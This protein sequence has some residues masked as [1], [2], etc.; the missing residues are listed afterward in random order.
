MSIP[1]KIYPK[2][3]V[4]VQLPKVAEEDDITMNDIYRE[5]LQ[6]KS[7]FTGGSAKRPFNNK[8]L[9][10]YL[11]VSTRTL[12]NWRDEGKIS[13]TQVKEVILYSMDDVEAFMKKHK[14][15]AFK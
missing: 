3:N 1:K 5:L 15:I 14:R 11:G 2:L 7:Y 10:E 8:S 4:A 12:Q 6:L 13:Y 9:S